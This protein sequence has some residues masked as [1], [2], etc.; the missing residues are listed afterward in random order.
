MADNNGQKPKRV[1]APSVPQRR[2]PQK[3]KEKKE[4]EAN[5]LLAAEVKTEGRGAALAPNATQVA[6]GPFSMGPS[7]PTSRAGFGGSM[8]QSI[9]LSMPTTMKTED[10]VQEYQDMKTTLGDDDRVPHMLSLTG[11]TVDSTGVKL[12]AMEV[13][14]PRLDD[15]V[16]RDIDR[17][18]LVQMP[19]VIPE[20]DECSLPVLIKSTG[21]PTVMVPPDSKEATEPQP[22]NEGTVRT[23][24][25]EGQVGRLV[26]RQSG[27]VQL[28]IGE[29][30]FD[31]DLAPP[32]S[33]HQQVV[34]IDPNMNQAFALGNIGSQ[35]IC[36]PNLDTLL[37][38]REAEIME[39]GK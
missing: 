9:M 5:S 18:H 14:P 2:A 25:Q 12:E 38:E 33:F 31:V 27:R 28:E 32:F 23:P 22:K 8:G 3:E 19:P 26:V 36:S 24:V 21:N 1:F 30:L 16:F 11:D 20:L 35:L 4:K 37:A 34:A 7:L 17:L 6:S 15:A 39:M 10:S 13:D 29:H